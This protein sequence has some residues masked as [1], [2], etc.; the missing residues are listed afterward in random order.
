MEI[1][2]KNLS[3]VDFPSNPQSFYPPTKNPTPNPPIL[4]LKFDSFSFQSTK[5]HLAADSNIQKNS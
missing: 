3:L 5:T 1:T 4:A 2:C